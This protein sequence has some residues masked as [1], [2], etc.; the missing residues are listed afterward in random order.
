MNILHL[1]LMA[2][3]QT[4]APG[5]DSIM[6]REAEIFISSLPAGLQKR[7]ETAVRKATGGD[8]SSLDSVRASRNSAFTP[9]Q[10]IS[11]IDIDGKYR[12]Y[13][14]ADRKASQLPLLIYLHGGGWCFGSVNSCAAFCSELTRES[15]IAVLAVEYPLAPEYPFPHALRFCSEALRW[16]HQNAGKF[17]F[18]G[19]QISMGGD[20]AGGNLALCAALEND[21]YPLKSLVLFY[22]VVKAWNDNSA[23]WNRYGEGYGLDSGIME[24]FNDAYIA[25]GDSK[26]PLV[27]PFCAVSERLAAL[28]EILMINADHD[29]LRDQGEEMSRKLSESG[30]KVTRHVLPGTTHLFITVPGQPSAFRRSV[31]L[32]SEF[33]TVK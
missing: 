15:G 24:A 11:C 5:N 31:T 30:V 28:P 7:Q 25:A 8:S 29:I 17:G 19:K 4:I 33:L 18:D 2:C 14:P 26:N 27:S 12:L 9:P 20:S 16:A 32:T 23:S 3:L 22:P 1:S 10:D 13:C 6:H 21:S